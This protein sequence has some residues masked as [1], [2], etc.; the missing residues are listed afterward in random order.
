M[1]DQGELRG[2][3][4]LLQKQEVFHDSAEVLVV[5]L[6]SYLQDDDQ[7]E[8]AKES[9]FVVQLLGSP[10]HERQVDEHQETTTRRTKSESSRP[11]DESLPT[12]LR[13]GGS[14]SPFT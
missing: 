5:L 6:G 14:L 10:R 12:A 3:R 1:D 11:A 9:E 2:S 8:D 7:V 13:A 4:Y